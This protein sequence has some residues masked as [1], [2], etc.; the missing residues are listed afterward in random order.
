MDSKCLQSPTR[1]RSTGGGT[2]DFRLTSWFHL[3]AALRSDNQAFRQFRHFPFRPFRVKSLRGPSR[4]TLSKAALKSIASTT[5][6]LLICRLSIAF[7]V[8]L[9]TMSI[10]D[11]CGWK[12]TCT[13][14]IIPVFFSH[15]LSLSWTSFSKTFPTNDRR[16]TGR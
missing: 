3:T 8:M 4:Q 1:R 10:V 16:E 12:P 13:S 11:Q 7:G 9:A 2:V 6:F 5:V 14:G 15:S